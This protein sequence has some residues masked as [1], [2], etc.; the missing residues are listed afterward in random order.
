MVSKLDYR[1]KHMI[2][3]QEPKMEVERIPQQMQK[4]PTMVE[5][6][7]NPS[8]VFYVDVDELHSF[9]EALNG[10]DSLHYKKAMDS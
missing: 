7:V 1:S 2:L 9:V 10:E 3:N 8:C 4:N 6:D 5:E